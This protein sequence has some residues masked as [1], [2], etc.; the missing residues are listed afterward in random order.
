MSDESWSYTCLDGRLKKPRGQ[1]WIITGTRKSTSCP[2]RNDHSH[3]GCWKTAAILATGGSA[4]GFGCGLFPQHWSY[5]DVA[6]DEG[7]AKP[8]N[9]QSLARIGCNVGVAAR[10]KMDAQVEDSSMLQRPLCENVQ[11]E[12]RG[13]R[14]EYAETERQPT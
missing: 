2:I 10:S 11:D 13:W 7:L 14:E 5:R 4:T 8:R 6:V 3:Y 1:R 9:Y 12:C